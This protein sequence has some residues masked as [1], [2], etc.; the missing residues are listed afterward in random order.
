M[1]SNDNQTFSDFW[2]SADRQF[3]DRS[4]YMT[5]EGLKAADVP[6]ETIAQSLFDFAVAEAT[7]SDEYASLESMTFVRH[8]EMFRDRLNALIG[9]MDAALEC[10]A[11]DEV[12]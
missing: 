3:A 6:Y 8:L 4:I 11:H 7:G 12:S 10:D 9:E 5:V 1:S 2:P